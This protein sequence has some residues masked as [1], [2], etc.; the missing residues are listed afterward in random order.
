LNGDGKISAEEVM[1]VLWKLGERCSLEDCNRMVR[2]VDADGDGLV[3]ME[4]FIKMMSS[5]N[6]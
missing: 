6:V 1:S 2:A 3:N 5:N 4:E